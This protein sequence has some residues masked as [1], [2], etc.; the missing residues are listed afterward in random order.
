[1]VDIS[2]MQKY[3]T[4]VW[5]FPEEIPSGDEIHGIDE[6]PARYPPIIPRVLIN[7]YSKQ[8]EFVLDPFSGGGTTLIEAK[9][10]N[11]NSLG[12][13]INPKSIEITKKKLNLITH[14][15]NITSKIILGDAKKL[16][17][18]D[19]V[20]DLVITSP[21]YWNLIKYSDEKECLANSN[22]INEYLD[23][24]NQSIRE[25]YRVLKKGRYCCIVIGD[26]TEGWKFH[27]L[28]YKTQVMLE[29]VGFTIQRI[30]IHIQ[31]RTNSFLHGNEKVKDKVLNKGLFL[32]AHEYVII[33][34]K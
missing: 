26:A 5:Y 1:M 16:F 20:I 23:S 28:G 34:K 15:Q 7:K 30:V 9:K 24:L 29:E 18:K 10:L 25:M 32:I 21:P 14:S 6:Y 12:I 17:F 8:N 4:T 22:S 31:C 13:D 11:R 19:E 27:P 2:W 3:E 33:A